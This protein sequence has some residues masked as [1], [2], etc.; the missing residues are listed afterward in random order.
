MSK[1]KSVIRF[2]FSQFANNKVFLIMTLV[3][4]LLAL[5]GPAVPVIIDRVGD[6]TA[7]RTIAVVDNTGTFD[8]ATLDAMLS[9]DVVMFTSI[10]AA[11][12]A[13]QD[14]THNYAL[15]INQYD[16][17]LAV[18]AMGVGVINLEHSIGSILAHF[19]QVGQLQAQGLSPDAAAGVLAFRPHSEV[20]NLGVSA[21]TD[22]D[23]FVQNMLFSYIMA[24]VLAIGLQ[25]GGGHLLTAVVREKS[26]KTM[27][28]LVTS[29]EPHIMMFG[30]VIGT[31]AA[32]LMQ[33]ITLVAAA[34]VSM[35][36]ITPAL[37]YGTDAA[38]SFTF[39]P[40][41]MGLLIIYFLIGFAMYAFIYAALAST[42]SRMEDATSMAQLPG[43]LLMAGMM[44]VV[45]G[46]TNPGA[47]WITP[48]SFVPFFAPFVM[49]MR[50]AMGT[51]AAWEIIVSITTSLATIGI[52]AWAGAKIYRMGTLMYGAKPT[53]KSLLAAFR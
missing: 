32:L 27:E 24:V 41:I 53:F 15:E 38:I 26:T 21:D 39:D 42:C 6:I 14:G 25:I 20:L 22:T 1:L 12:D 28:L 48:A 29:C 30:K 3:I 50:I 17:T 46:M 33:I 16:F 4:A 8:Q 36:V 18:M 51:A 10:Q 19:H 23:T 34:A 31:G 5:V 37:E 9:P 44:M 40:M 47:A 13:V 45:F 11:H 7:N 2:E 52:I 43:L 35:L 49:F